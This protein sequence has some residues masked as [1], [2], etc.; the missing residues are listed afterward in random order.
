MATLIY[1]QKHV[2]EYRYDSDTKTYKG[3]LIRTGENITFESHSVKE[4]GKIFRKVV[5]MLEPQE[6]T[7]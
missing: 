4:I 5:D 2:G 1:H 6:E 7:A 3:K